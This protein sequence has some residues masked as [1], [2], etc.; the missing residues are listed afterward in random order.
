[1]HKT[2]IAI[3]LVLLVGIAAATPDDYLLHQINSTNWYFET[4]QND[5]AAGDYSYQAF[6][7]NISTEYRTF[8]YSLPDGLHQI[9]ATHWYFK[10]TQTDLS[11]GNYSYQAFAN[12]IS[13]DYQV[14]EYASPTP[15]PTNLANTSGNFWVNHTWDAGT[16]NV[17]DSYNVSVNSVWHN[18][19]TDTFY[20]DTYTAHAWQNVTVYAY[21]SSGTGTLSA[22]S[23]SQDTQIPN[24]PVTI[25]NTSDWSG[26][27]GEN[28]YV[29]YDATDVDS[30]APTFS[31]NRTDLFTDFSTSTG[32][33]NWTAIAGT[34]YV[35][36]GVS[37]GY[38]STSNY[39]MT[40]AAA[41]ITI[42]LHSISPTTIF[43][44][45]TGAVH[46]SYIVKSSEPLNLSTL[47]FLYGINHTP[48][49]DMHSYI[50][51]PANSIAAE[52]LYRAPNRNSTPYL[53][54]ENNDNITGRNVWQWGGGD[55][56]SW[57]I[58]KTP[59][60]ATHTWVNATGITEHIFVSSFY[61]KKK[62]MYTAPKTAFEVNS[63]QGLI[64]KMWDNEI[65]RG[66]SL[67]Y[68]AN[69]YFDTSW[70]STVP[71][72]PIEIWYC[73][74]SFNI[75]TDDPTGANCA[76]IVEWDGNR[77]INHS[78]VPSSN[79]SYC[80]PLSFS[81]SGHDVVPTEIAY[82]YLTSGTQ[83][84]K[85]Y[86]LNATDYDPGQCN[87]TFAQTETMWTYSEL[88]G[89]STAVAYTPSFFA[90]FVRDNE[91]FLHHLYI[92]NDDGEW[93][94]SGINNITIGVAR[95]PVAPAA[96]EYFN[97][98]CPTYGATYDYMMDAT[99][100]AEN[101]FIG[102]DCPADPDGGVVTHNLTLHYANETFVAVI[103]NTLSTTGDESIE[104][105]F[106]ATPYRSSTDAYTLKCVST[107][108]EGTVATKWLGSNFTLAEPGTQG[109]Y[110]NDYL[111]F[112]GMNDIPTL[113]AVI[114]DSALISYDAGSDSY[115]MHI[116]FFKSLC[117]DT[118]RFNE[119]VHLESL[120]N[121][122]VAYFRFAGDTRFDYATIRGWNTTSDTA[123]PI[124]DAYRGY[125]IACCRTS[126]NITNSDLSYLGSDVYQQEGLNFISNDV[127]YLIF[128][129][130]LS[131]N[132]R[133][134]IVEDCENFNISHC[135]IHD[136]AEVGI[137]IYYSDNTIIENTT[138]A[139][140][141]YDPGIYLYE[142]SDATIRYNTIRDCTDYGI[143]IR[144][145][146]NNNTFTGNDV[147]GNGIYDYYFSSDAINNTIRDPESD[148]DKIRCTSTSEVTV[149][150]TD[151]I[152]FTEDSINITRAYPANFSM[153]VTG[154]SQ[155]FN[156]TQTGMSI[157]PGSDSV[158]IWNFVWEKIVTLNASNVS[159]SPDVW[160]NATNPI[161]VSTNISIYRD[162]VIYANETTD[163]SGYFDYNY[164]GGWS[165]HWFEFIPENIAPD[166]PTLVAPANGAT[167]T[168]TNP[169]LRVT[170]TD[171]DGEPMSVTFYQQGGSQIGSTQTGIA[172]GSTA[173][174]VWSGR[175]YSTAYYW[176]AVADDGNASTQ[177]DTWHFTTQSSGGGGSSHTISI[178][179][180]NDWDGN[181]G[182]QA[183]IDFGYWNED[184]DNPV[185]TTNATE[186]SLDSS[187]GIWTWATG[188]GD[189]GVYHWWFRVTNAYGNSDDCTVTVTVYT[190]DTPLN[191]GST[192]GN[193]WVD[194][195]WNAVAGASGYRV[196][197]NGAWHNG[198]DTHY[199][200]TLLAPHGWSN[201]TLASYNSTTGVSSYISD[202]VQ[203]PNNP[204]TITNYS[205]Q[206]VFVA[207]VVYVDLDH[208]DLD[209]DTPTFS[210][211]RT[212]LFTDFDTATGTG[213][214]TTT[215]NGT[216]KIDFGVS[217]GWGSVSNCTVTVRVGERATL[218]TTIPISIWITV[219]VLLF[220][221]VVYTLHV[222]G[223]VQKI[224][225]G[226]ISVIMAY[227]QSQQIVSGNV[228]QIT[229]LMNSADVMVTEKV[230]VVIPELAYLLLFV[231]V[232]MSLVTSAF[233][234]KYVQ[235]LYQKA[236]AIKSTEGE[237]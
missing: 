203:I 176:Y 204:I 121:E 233:V 229:T 26:D 35:D 133:G 45:Y 122:D 212:D 83:S 89:E 196:C 101:F 7:N 98:T 135:N 44:N 66:R 61:L 193:F 187:T 113:H 223:Y 14:L 158:D 165:G 208:A 23:I 129:T 8:T 207:D 228:V 148:T 119:T 114:A 153:H 65:L 191:L 55:N 96:F 226:M 60:N 4:T 190:G 94:H 185:F 177:S 56:D 9:N 17:T 218:P 156:I 24:N 104:V 197:V 201:I 124:T 123:A 59:I 166:K 12:N 79:A 47:A 216:F 198:T 192:T 168:S 224:F 189:V 48:T 154:V 167:G 183:T 236:N 140:S 115:T 163:A 175:S 109:Y 180:C 159:G 75:S 71:T 91:E 152:V 20:N 169:T 164:T 16:G 62:S 15:D 215:A 219:T 102:I 235:Y 103:N 232:I 170:V 220:A 210:C 172:N 134:V 221:F 105:N 70:E 117:N 49:S 39:T 195:T 69:L 150:N 30:D 126:G 118:F 76:K 184:S 138:I 2:L 211:S 72:D 27:E 181:A 25:T 234:M 1:M 97:I 149:E 162:A 116:P 22:G 151:N 82:I 200:N 225:A 205:D 74:S 54:W 107:D 209:G 50:A 155:T 85:S 178:T 137:G 57:W 213:N 11:Y 237:L 38:G 144:A 36:F 141:G 214:W 81:A 10:I 99:Y 78:W 18:T 87:L 160:F 174:V 92:A 80:D 88:A 32:Q 6:A 63:Q 171:S 131:H 120:N 42:T 206:N 182:T 112:W 5:L 136:N 40:I 111:M 231:A 58:T 110:V 53:S 179:G 37:D 51:A 73:N 188:A 84:S 132:S 139:D 217:D 108:D 145:D 143:R 28:V 43:T 93:A 194:H 128:N 100:D 31:C 3:L 64:I 33:G 67:D 146:S 46:A 68:I 227:I 106:T 41:G 157:T 86:V 147:T 142:S 173:S 222:K 34:Y 77:W 161:W 13:S 186:G 202:D 90:T 130:T 199:L 52:G 125:L 230:E 19:T 21:N 29:D 127:D 95:Y